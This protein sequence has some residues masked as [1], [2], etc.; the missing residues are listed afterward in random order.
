MFVLFCSSKLISSSDSS[1]FY[2]L[3]SWIT[4]IFILKMA[5][6]HVGKESQNKLSQDFTFGLVSLPGVRWNKVGQSALFYHFL[7]N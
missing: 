2:Y 6:D 1:E 5:M 7:G 4:N 3:L